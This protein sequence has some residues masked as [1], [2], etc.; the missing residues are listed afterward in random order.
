MVVVAP[1]LEEL[2]PP[3]LKCLNNYGSEISKCQFYLDM[4]NECRRGVVCLSF[5]SNWD[6]SWILFSLPC[7]S[8]IRHRETF[9]PLHE[10]TMASRVHLVES[11]VT[12]SL[13]CVV[14][15]DFCLFW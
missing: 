11:V 13:S 5:C 12:F 1:F 9:N 8:L 10:C 7:I 4:L 6:Y 3:L 2:G 15:T 14:G